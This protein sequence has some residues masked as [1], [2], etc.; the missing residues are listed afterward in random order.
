MFSILVGAA[1]AGGTY[2]YAKKK[3]ASTGQSVAVATASGVASGAATAATL[4][5]M[6]ALWPLV[7]I[8]GVAGGAYYMGKK[9]SP[10]ALPP[11]SSG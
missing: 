8:G 4:F 10:K 7:L 2:L 9:K 5:V 11:S 3:K 6:S 1:V